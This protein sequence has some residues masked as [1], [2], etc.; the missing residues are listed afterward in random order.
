V[1]ASLTARAFSIRLWGVI[2]IG[3]PIGI[4][5][6]TG[7]V[8]GL[9]LGARAHRGV[10]VPDVSWMVIPTLISFG[11]GPFVAAVRGVFDARLYVLLRQQKVKT[12]LRLSNLARTEPYPEEGRS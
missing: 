3:L 4:A 6:G 2:V 9:A 10:A 1:D 5:F 8:V 12:D 7:I 11:L